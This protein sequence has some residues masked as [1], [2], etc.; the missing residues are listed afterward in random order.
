MMALEKSKQIKLILVRHEQV[1]AFMADVW[2]RLTGEAGVCLSTLGPGATNLVTG[3]ANAFLDRSPL[4]AITGQGELRRIHKESHQVLSVLRLMRPITKWTQPIRTPSNVT[5]IVRKAFK[6]AVSEKPG[7]THIEL[8]QDVAAMEVD[9][10]KFQPIPKRTIRVPD[11]DPKSVAEA[12]EII[13]SAKHPLILAGNGVVRLKA[14]KQLTEFVNTTGIGVITTFMAKGAIPWD[15]P[16]CMFATG[17]E[18]AT[19]QPDLL[20]DPKTDVVIAVGYD[21][22]EYHAVYWNPD[23]K[24]IIVHIDVQEAEVDDNYQTRCEVVG[25]IQGALEM[26]MEHHKRDPIQLSK[27][28]HERLQGVRR[29]ILEDFEAFKNDESTGKIKPQKVV[30]DIRE[31]MGPSDILVCDVGA[32]KMWI[33]RNYHCTEP[34][35]CIFSNGLCAMGFALPGAMAAKLLHPDKKVLAVCGDGGFL[36]NVQDMETSKRIGTNIVVM[37]WE[38]KCYGQIAW[39]QDNTFGRHTDLSF[40]NPDFVKLAESFGWAGIRVENSKDIKPSLVKA[41]NMDRPCLI[42]LPIDYTENRKLS[43]KMG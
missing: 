36:M 1:A 37:V 7:A 15:N 40:N 21:L 24:K 19:G 30:S 8:S 26:L 38:D 31:V 23:K 34:N 5:E 42:S 13:K 20:E 3:I 4:V 33:A 32:H 18:S 28:Y 39:K 22:V 12:W 14:H 16:H 10:N 43:S 17:I 2:G 25:D 27:E 41:F 29:A 35:T 6:E 9:P 11:P